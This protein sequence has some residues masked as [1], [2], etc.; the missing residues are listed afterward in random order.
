LAEGALP[1]TPEEGALVG[2]TCQVTRA[3]LLTYDC[4]IDKDTKHRT[5]DLIRPVPTN[6]PVPDRTTIQQNKRFSFFYL[7]AGGDPLPES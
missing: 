7:P 4:E 3:M 2:A 6:M 1:T 5:V